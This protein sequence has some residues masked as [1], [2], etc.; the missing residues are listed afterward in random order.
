MNLM[1]AIIVEH[2]MQN[3]E[4]RTIPIRIDEEQEIE[5]HRRRANLYYKMRH[6]KL[7]KPI[8]NSLI[9]FVYY[10]L[11]APASIQAR[12]KN[13]LDSEYY[14]K[15]PKV[16]DAGDLKNGLLMMHNGVVIKPSSYYGES[17]T[18]VFRKTK[19]VHEP[20]QE[21]LFSEVLNALPDN[22][23]M[24]ELGSYWAFYSLWFKKTLVNSTSIMVEP[25][26]ERMQCGIDNFKVNGLDGKFSQGYVGGEDGISESGVRVYS[27]NG[28]FEEYNLT[29]VDVLHVDIQGAEEDMLIASTNL[30]GSD[31]IKHIFLSTHSDTIHINC[32]HIL[33]QSGYR[34]LADQP[35]EKSDS[36]DGFLYAVFN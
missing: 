31:V 36:E 16:K 23:V 13:V 14:M 26:L 33:E 12:V 6:S 27:L 11:G 5:L 25:E 3:E 21:Y 7:L 35:L 17:M 19:G 34:V 28:L 4:L 24:M 8:F 18:Y 30:L 20:Y 22:A 2:N 10:H 1:Q 29:N 15:I 9:R 32:R